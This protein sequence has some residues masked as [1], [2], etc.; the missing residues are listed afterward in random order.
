MQL[1]ENVSLD[2]TKLS[3]VDFSTMRDVFGKLGITIQKLD[4]SD[5]EALFL[6]EEEFQNKSIAKCEGCGKEIFLNT[7][8]HIVH[9]SKLVYCKNPA[10]FNHF[11]ANRKMR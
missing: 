8:G 6:S 4:D 1:M 11:L 10:C 3:L 2:K 9:G 5:K 7:L